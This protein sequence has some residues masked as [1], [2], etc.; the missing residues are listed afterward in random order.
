M[1]VPLRR[2][3]PHIHIVIQISITFLPDMNSM[4]HFP[5][6]M[7]GMM[8]QQPMDGMMTNMNMNM[9]HPMMTNMIDQNM[10]M[11]MMNQSSVASA[12]HPITLSSCTL[13]P[14]IPGVQTPQRREKPNG[15]RTVFVGG[16][17][18]ISLELLKEIFGRFGSICD[19][20]SP[21]DGL[22]YVRFDREESVEFSFNLTGYRFKFLDQN[23]N[24]ATTMF[25]DYAAVSFVIIFVCNFILYPV[26]SRV[27]RGMVSLH[28]RYAVCSGRT[29]SRTV[30]FYLIVLEN[31]N[32]SIRRV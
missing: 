21:R 8:G 2:D 10:M 11:N 14:P 3:C 9:S 25:L 12:I 16:M 29:E 20:K 7:Q 17:P 18:T 26:Y 5:Q 19:I 23:D 22:Y 31:E 30:L 6:M 15:C 24:E 4:M 32:N 1:L 28:F 27:E 13:L